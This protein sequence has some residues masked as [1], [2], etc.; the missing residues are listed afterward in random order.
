MERQ[1]VRTW[2]DRAKPQRDGKYVMSTL[3]LTKAHGS[4][5]DIFVVDGAPLDHFAS[6]DELT[7]AVGLLCDRKRGLGGDGVYFVADH[8]DGTAR[9][10]FYNPDGSEALLCGNGMRCAGRIL[11]DRHQAESVVVEQGPYSFTVRDR[12]RTSHGVRQVSVELPAVDFAPGEPIV[13]EAGPHGEYV[14]RLLPAFHPSRHVTAVAVPNSHLITV[15]DAYDEAE[16][17][18]TGRR[19]AGSP[20]VFPIGAN[21]SFVLPLSDDEVFIHTY[22]RGAGLTPSC[23]SGIAASRATLSRLGLVAPERPVTVRNPGGVARSYLQTAGDAWQPV[24][25]G[26]A[27]LVYDAELDPAMLLG[28]GPVTYEGA[29]HMAEISAFA[30]LSRENMKVLHEAGIHPTE[31]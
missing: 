30:E 24:L 27:T 9:A 31:V 8:G 12:G 15:I 18:E 28:D 3:S 5:N 17:I 7:R 13:T 25:E 16:L 1:P 10:W 20:G 21:L 26:N 14:D 6:A 4:R 11:L 22:E 29:A 2:R 19:V 23:G